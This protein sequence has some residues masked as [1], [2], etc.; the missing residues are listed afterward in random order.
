MLL[1]QDRGSFDPAQPNGGTPRPYTYLSEQFLPLLRGAG[2]DEARL[3][4]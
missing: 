1:S 3:R 2:F 4:S